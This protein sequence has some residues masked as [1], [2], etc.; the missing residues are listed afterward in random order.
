MGNNRLVFAFFSLAILLSMVRE[1]NA[2]VACARG[3]LVPA[4]VTEA[5]P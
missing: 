1:W 3:T 2:P 4:V 5:L